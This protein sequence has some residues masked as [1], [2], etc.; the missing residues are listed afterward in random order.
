MRHAFAPL[1]L[2]L[3]ALLPGAPSWAGASG[4]GVSVGITL[5]V[6]LAAGVADLPQPLRPG[7]CRSRSLGERTRAGAEVTCALG[8]YASIQAFRYGALFTWDAA[9]AAGAFDLRLGTVTIRRLFD[10]MQGHPDDNWWSSPLEMRV[11]F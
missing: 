4:S 8:E 3:M 11:T 6:P 9:P 1:T 10:L 7:A 2:A 5:A